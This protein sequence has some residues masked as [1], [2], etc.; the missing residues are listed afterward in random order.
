M[1]KIT[2]YG[3]NG[4]G[5]FALVSDEDFEYLNQFIWKVDGSGYPYRTIKIKKN[6][7]ISL[8]MH[9]DILKLVGSQPADHKDINRLNNQRDN[10]RI[11]T[12]ADNNRNRGL[13]RNNT[14]GYIGVCYR[15]GKWRTKRWMASITIDN[16]RKFIADFNTKEEAAKAY[17]LAATKYF[18]QFARLNPIPQL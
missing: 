13:L 10:L 1:K 7:F 6:N 14:S 18:G 8:R 5:K 16:K 15:K 9:R 4:L 2:L 3:K 17:N 12:K 11:C